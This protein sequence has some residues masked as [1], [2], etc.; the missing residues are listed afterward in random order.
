MV[1]T[2][3][4]RC[5]NQNATIVSL[6]TIV[7]L[8]SSLLLQFMTVGYISCMRSGVRQSFNAKGVELPISHFLSRLFSVKNSNSRFVPWLT[9]DGILNLIVLFEIV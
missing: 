1:I 9:T 4:I 2:Q 7:R 8:Y 6:Y 3:N 5:S